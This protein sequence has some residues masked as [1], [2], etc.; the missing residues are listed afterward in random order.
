MLIVIDPIGIIPSYIAQTG[1]FD[2]KTRKKI[3]L[4][5]VLIGGLVNIIFVVG[6]RAILSFFGIQTGAFYI[7]GGIL[8]F[9]IAFEMIYSKPTHRRVPGKQSVQESA[10][11]SHMVAIFPLAIPMIAGPGCISVIMMYMT[12][13]HTWL[14]S[15]GLVFPALLICLVVM[16]IV[17]RASDF[18][19][20]IL[21]TMGIFVLEK[22]MGLILSGF[23]VQLIYNG[24]K[25]LEI[26]S[27]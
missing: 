5:A 15:F 3:V 4:E 23:A 18:L 19:L 22:I 10:E 17:L 2:M 14:H 11:N 16:Y 13:E 8:F 7:A 1:N 20:R 25:A 24:L 26:L 6:G 27:A 12:G 21:G 9:L